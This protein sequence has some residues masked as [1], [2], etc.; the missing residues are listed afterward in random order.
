MMQKA[1]MIVL[2]FLWWHYVYA[3]WVPQKWQYKVW[4]PPSKECNTMSAQHMQIDSISREGTMVSSNFRHWPM[5]W[6]MPSH[7][8]SSKQSS[9]SDSDHRRFYSS[10]N[11]CNVGTPMINGWVG[12]VDNVDLCI[13][14]ARSQ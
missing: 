13:M 11:L 8:G 10:S 1:V 14:D 9:F 7:M 5:Q 12:F 3:V 6:S 2:C 4:S